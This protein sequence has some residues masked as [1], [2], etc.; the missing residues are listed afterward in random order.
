M[1]V[2]EIRPWQGDITTLAVDA[3]VN[4]ANNSLM[5]G[6]GVCGAIFQAAGPQ[7]DEA[8]DAIEWCD[9]GNAIA[10]P[11]FNLPAKWVIHAV[12]PVWEGGDYGEADQLT[13]CY[14][15][16]LEVAV[17]LGARVVAFPAISTGIY[18][19]PA[20]A[21][22]E[23]AIATVCNACEDDFD[24]IVLVAFDDE[25]FNRYQNLLR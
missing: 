18:E 24:E 9:S 4:A 22:A 25:T 11:G 14:R 13:S 21:A 19:F 15:S 23:I 7:L 5:R 8:C 2:V 12:G 10:T 16:A 6:G 1:P 20:E 17:D 3:I